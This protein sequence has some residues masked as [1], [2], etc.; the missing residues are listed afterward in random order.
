VISRTR[1][2]RL[3]AGYRDRPAADL[4]A[5]CRTLVRISQMLSEIAEIT[6][7]D[8]NPLLA[9]ED[10]VL[11]LDARIGIAP[12]AATALARFAIRPYPAELEEW[13]S[14]Q[15]ERI[16]L[17]PIKPEDGSQHLAFFHALDPEDVRMRAFTAVREIPRSQLGRLTQ[18][19]YD[20][21]MEF[22][23]TTERVPGRPE[24]LGVVRAVADPDNNS[25]EFG[26]VVAS[27]LKGKKLGGILLHKMI[28]Y[29]RSRGTPEVIG[30][31][32]PY[33]RPL[34][35]LVRRFGF[36]AFRKPDS[37]TVSLRL[38]LRPRVAT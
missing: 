15:G 30:E 25:A 36:E 1:V 17:R 7:L 20:R 38:H 3:L 26:I 12:A 18:I 14:W 29:L 31:T 10:G 35:A 4:E 34:L 5:I 19:D 24:T 27:H 2:A 11:A 9:D 13:I 6:E 8:I 37:D 23:A 28:E 33:N 32:L 21:E 16:L 22:I